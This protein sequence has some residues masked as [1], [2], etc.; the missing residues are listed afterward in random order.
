MKDALSDKTSQNGPAVEINMSMN[1]IF[2]GL[3]RTGRGE[4]RAKKQTFNI[5]KTGNAV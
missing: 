2:D 1:Y 4:E 5:I 3:L